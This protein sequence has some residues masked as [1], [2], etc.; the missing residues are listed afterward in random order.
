MIAG[1]TNVERAMLVF[2]LAV[3]AVFEATSTSH[4]IDMRQ[5]TVVG[6]RASN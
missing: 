2:V 4:P 1:R 3:L 6:V 5:K